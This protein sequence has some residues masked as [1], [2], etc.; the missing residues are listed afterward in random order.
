MP[1]ATFNIIG[2]IEDFTR[3]DNLYKAL[4]RESDKLLSSWEIKIDVAY[5]EKQG[6]KE[7]T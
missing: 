5:S 1:Q 3:L 4:V 2:N 6:E 7:T